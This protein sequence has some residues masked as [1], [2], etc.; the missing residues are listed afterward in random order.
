MRWAIVFHGVC[1]A[2]IFFRAKTFSDALLVIGNIQDLS[3]VQIVFTP[4]MGFLALFGAAHFVGNRYQINRRLSEAPM[5]VCGVAL[6][7]A[8]CA[9]W[10]Y[11]PA[12][13]K[14][15]IYFQF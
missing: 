1:F 13:H 8:L 5:W 6:G 4:L 2:W 11:T 9:L 14:A 10:I 7:L 15:F 3:L 12:E